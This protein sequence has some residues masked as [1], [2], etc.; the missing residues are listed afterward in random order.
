VDPMHARKMAALLQAV[1]TSDQPV[2]L[3]EEAAAG[4]GV[5]KPRSKVL[6]EATDVWSFLFWQLGVTIRDA[7]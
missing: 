2:L 7:S 5:G 3:R 4:H 6:D 1:S